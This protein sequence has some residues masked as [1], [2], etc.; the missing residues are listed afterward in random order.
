MRYKF[1]LIV[2]SLI[3]FLQFSQSAYAESDGERIKRLERDMLVMQRQFYGQDAYNV[4]EAGGLNSKNTPKA[5]PY[6]VNV[7]NLQVQ[8][9][10]LDER[11]RQMTGQIEELQHKNMLLSEQM[12]RMSSD[13]DLRFHSLSQ[14]L[15]VPMQPAAFPPVVSGATIPSGTSKLNIAVTPANMAP[16]PGAPK[17]GLVAGPS[18]IPTMDTKNMSPEAQYNYAFN[19][20][21]QNKFQEAEFAFRNFIQDNKG[22]P[23]LSNAY[24]W[25]GE[26]YYVRK[27][28]TNST[29]QF[30]KG[31]QISPKG[32]KAP[33]NMLK[34][35]LS[36]GNSGK[37]S[38]ACTTF[39]KLQNDFK[40][41]MPN[42]LKRAQD[43]AKKLGC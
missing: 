21:S 5:S 1:I 23:L 19:L 41:A 8:L 11:L 24:Y 26:S 7:S 40:D 32:Q 12:R 31:Y 25:L 17:G 39:K 20:L 37:K 13:M 16:T 29:V 2:F 43:E 34:L 22:H 28:Y 42:V 33:D 35:G 4:N 9:S 36:L 3:S 30:L 18:G 6:A 14:Q 27:D 38:E 10:A 15:P